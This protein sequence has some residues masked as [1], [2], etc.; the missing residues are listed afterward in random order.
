MKQEEVNERNGSVSIEAV[1]EAL[2]SIYTGVF[3]I[4]PVN[5]S[6]VIIR[7]P[8]SIRNLLDGITSAQQALNHAIQQ[9]VT[10]EDALDIIAFVNLVTLSQRMET[11][12]CI[13]I[14]YHGMIS[15]WVRGSF[16]E[17]ARDTSGR[18]TQ[19]LYAYQVIDTEKRKE[20]DHVKQLK[21]SYTLAE[22]ENK[23]ER[24]SLENEKKTLTD[25]LNYQNNF[26]NIIMEQLDC[27]I[28]AYTIPG[29]SLLQINREALRIYGWKNKEEAAV[30]LTKN[31]GN[32]RFVNPEDATRLLQL[33]DHEGDVKYQIIMNEGTSEE[34]RILAESK[35]L[36]GRYGGKV[37]MSTL[38]DITHV[39]NLE[40]EKVSLTDKNVFLTNENEELQ[41]ARDAKTSFL[42]RMSHDIRTPMNGIMGLIDINEKHA[43]DIEFT[44]QN[45]RKAKVAANHLLS[46][47]ND[48]L[49]LSKLEESGIQLSQTPFN[50]HRLMDDI[51]TIVELRAK[52]N[53]ITM[54]IENDPSVMQ[55]PYL[56]GSPL[57]VRQLYINILSNAIKYNKKNGSILYHASVE[58]LDAEHILSTVI[59]K[60]TGI[61]MSEEFQ[62]HLFDPFAREHEEMTGRYE[63]TGLGMSIVK[64][65][66][67]KMGGT[68]QVES[69]VGEGTCFTVQIPFRL[70]AEAD[71]RKT[72]EKPKVDDITGT[73]VLLVEDNE[74]NMDIAEI[75]LTDAGADITKAM[76]GQQAVDL[77]EKNEPG[78]FDV[79]LMDV[80]MPVMNG[81]EATRRIRALDRA[82]A[83]KIPVIAMTANAFAEDVEE[84]KQAGMNDHLSKPLDAEKMLAMIAR[85]K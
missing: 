13:N 17:V 49:E 37:I 31:A 68:I 3:L 19:I 43:Q 26:T 32:I 52:D 46:L 30:N 59:I 60:D 85:F 21:D 45:R 33:R 84:A 62:Q 38:M 57:H 20:L 6:Y 75:L 66:V 82:D 16:I 58:R 5:D 81:Y 29:R 18:L 76:N 56:W 83:K 1:F 72:E 7:A 77:F 51:F 23:E 27:G 64:Q 80:M 22:K 10:T 71:V 47:I 4:D 65:L 24:Q 2:S 41:R 12:K 11:E 39:T 35:S 8:E 63:G 78:T 42:A 14:D 28:L 44:T 25:D 61:G 73:N 55:Y 53:G 74:L 67:D 79:I 40:E 70:A 50:M 15:G 69:R 48:V 34:R 54:D 36:S 9:T